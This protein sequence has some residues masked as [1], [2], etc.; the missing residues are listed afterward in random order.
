MLKIRLSRVLTLLRTE[1]FR[2]IKTAKRES[3]QYMAKQR[4]IKQQ[5]DEKTKNETFY[6]IPVYGRI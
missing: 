5:N 3:R 2:S 4:M 1:T 6:R